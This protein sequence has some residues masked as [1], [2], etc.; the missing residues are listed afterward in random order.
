M[1]GV[2]A[3]VHNAQIRPKKMPRCAGDG[4]ELEDSRGTLLQMQLS[5]QEPSLDLFRGV[6]LFGACASWRAKEINR[7]ALGLF[8]LASAAA[9]VG[10]AKPSK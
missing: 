7:A 8:R 4:L 1:L 2:A 6:A 5:R 10:G 9:V 3:A